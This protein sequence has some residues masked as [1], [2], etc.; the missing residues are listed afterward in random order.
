MASFTVESATA[1]AAFEMGDISGPM[2]PPRSLKLLR[3]PD[4]A[5]AGGAR[6]R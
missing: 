4:Q 1:D 3:T 5:K 2:S 6:E